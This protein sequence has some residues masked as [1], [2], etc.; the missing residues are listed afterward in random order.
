MPRTAREQSTVGMQ[1]KRVMSGGRGPGFLPTKKPIGYVG[2]YIGNNEPVHA[3][4]Q[5]KAVRIDS[6]IDPIFRRDFS[7]PYV[8][9]AWMKNGGT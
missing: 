8:S 5:A 1:V 7:G 2:I 3:S 6:L 9:K 4:L